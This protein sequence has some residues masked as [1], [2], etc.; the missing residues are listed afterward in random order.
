MNAASPKNLDAAWRFCLEDYAIDLAWSPGSDRIAVAA[1]GGPIALLDSQNGQVMRTLAGHA[2]GAMTIAWHPTENRLA[3]GGQDGFARVWPDDSDEPAA[4]AGGGTWVERIAWS[5]AGDA[6]ATTSGRTLKLWHRDANLM[7]AFPPAS[8]TISDLAWRPDGKLVAASTYGG[9][10]LFA[11][12]AAASVRQYEWKGSILAIAWSP[13]GRMLASGNQDSSVHL[14]HTDSG[15][16]LHMSGYALKV[17]ELAWSPDSRHLATG[18]GTDVVVWK[19][20]GKGPANTKPTMLR[21]HEQ[22]ITQLAWAPNGKLLA[23]A[24]QAGRVTLW[25]NGT[26]AIGCGQLEAG[27]AV[28]KLAWNR[29]GTRLLAADSAGNVALFRAPA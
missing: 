19:C 7:Q 12:D 14:W 23:S 28:T 4:I 3:S 22:P 15:A 27:C 2:Q 21:M 11:R 24:C 9:I 6:L 20:S 29:R 26:R 8:S 13:D 16:D 18:G 5:P 17:R 10:S 1:G 25:R